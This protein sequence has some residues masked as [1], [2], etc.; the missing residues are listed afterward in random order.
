MVCVAMLAGCALTKPM[1]PSVTPGAST[2]APVA[3][4]T[5]SAA[6]TAP[7][8]ALAV[9]DPSV[10]V[11]IGARVQENQEKGSYTYLNL[12]TI[13]GAAGWTDQLRAD[14]APELERFEELSHGTLQPPYPELS[15]NWQL[16]GASQRAIGVRLVTDEL[17]SDQTFAGKVET[18]WWDP[19]IGTVRPVQDLVRADAVVEF[20]DRLRAAAQ[21][22]PHIDAAKFEEQLQGEWQGIDS[23]AFTTAGALW[24]EFDRARASQMDDPAGV[25][26]DPDGLLSAFGEDARDSAILPRDPALASLATP[27]GGM[28]PATT[29]AP[30]ATISAATPSAATAPSATTT[31][32][33]T[34]IPSAQPKPPTTPKPSA[35][36]PP[37]PTKVNCAKL[38]CVALTFDD[39]PV[40][41]TASLLTLLKK[42]HVHAT[43]FMVGSNVA[44]HP[45][46]VRRM[47]ADGNVLGNHTWDHA[48][49]T[50]LSAAGV[51][52]EIV[53]T[54]AAIKKA[55]GTTPVLLRPP[56]G[57]T[58]STVATIARQ[59]G[60]AQILWN[61]DPLDWKDRNSATVTKRVLARARAGS[62]V[63]SHDIHPT[64]RA[65]YAAIIDGLRAKGFTLVTVPELLGS[66][67]KPGGKYFSR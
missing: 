42:K 8:D 17:G 38:K 41:G 55:T 10:V 32:P 23:V 59:L 45:A 13:P 35:S 58:N 53:R 50:R 16:V 7:V 31:P 3:S 65:A 54:N 56:Y 57:A 36:P 67:L 46:L 40:A 63:L 62:I 19:A 12:P 43:F 14:V 25:V 26:V 47:L 18:S 9:V 34:T 33:A 24:V 2:A 66:R 5:P 1:P 37:R 21:A 28:T 51:Q 30:S 11:G 27:A 60:M 48:Q 52:Q 15:V 20:F 64:T 4:P 44:L 39:G 6:V 29:Q 49:L 61:V 22:D